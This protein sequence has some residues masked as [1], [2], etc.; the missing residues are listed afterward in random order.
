MKWF[1]LLCVGSCWLGF[2]YAYK[3][4]N[5]ANLIVSGVMMLYCTIN[6]AAVEIMEKLE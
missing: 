5:T 2:L 1:W 4:Q 3:D 6:Y